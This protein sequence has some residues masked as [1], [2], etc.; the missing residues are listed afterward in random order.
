[1]FHVWTL[2]PAVYVYLRFIKKLKF[3]NKIQLSLGL[4]AVV[5]CEFHLL[6]RLAFGTMFSPE[7]PQLIMIVLG[8]IFGS[9]IFLALMLL[10]QDICFIFCRVFLHRSVTGRAGGRMLML[11]ASCLLAAVGVHNAIKTPVVQRSELTL[12]KL[13]SEFDGF[14]IVQLTDL[15]ASRLL[16]HS[17]M[18]SV[19][20]KTNALHPD[21]IVVTGDIA[22]GTVRDRRADVSSLS[23]LKAPY[24]VY[25]IT[26]NHEYY[27][28]AAAWT[29]EYTRLGL[30]FLNNTNVRL[31]KDGASI[32]LAGVTDEVAPEYGGEGPDLMKALNGGSVKGMVILLDHRPG[33]AANSAITGVSLQLS[34]HTHG[35]MISGLDAVAASANNGFVSGLYQVGDMALYVSNGAGLWNGF[36]LRL[37]K[38]SEI[39]FITLRAQ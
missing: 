24:G 2:L 11:V 27:F 26:G 33:S 21:L 31:S 15:H 39:T 30:H 28:N 3:S 35:G 4:F 19:M 7:L 6:S 12:R 9:V 32:V 13:P 1:M 18:Q 5:V 37:G 22:D 34:G 38:P 17:W 36:P 20:D 25:A 16:P 14:T 8:W 29:E 10:L 23:S